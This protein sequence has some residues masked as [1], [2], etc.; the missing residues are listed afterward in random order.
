MNTL[1]SG[2]VAESDGGLAIH[3]GM[4]DP[5]SPL[6]SKAHLHGHAERRIHRVNQARATRKIPVIAGLS[7]FES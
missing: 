1:D 4:A 2:A 6:R 7:L 5:S 3:G